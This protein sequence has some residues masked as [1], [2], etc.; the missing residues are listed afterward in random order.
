ML[1]DL[2]AIC[3]IHADLQ[4]TDRLW[5]QLR[6]VDR[7]LSRF[8]PQQTIPHWLILLEL[9]LS[10]L[11]PAVRV[12][13]AENLQLPGDSI[14]RLRELEQQRTALS[15]LPAAQR[16][17]QVVQILGSFDRSTLILLAATAP[18]PIRQQIWQYLTRWSQ[19]KSPLNGE[20]LKEL[21]YKPGKQFKQILRELKIATVDGM[22]N[23]RADAEAFL[24]E[25]F[26]VA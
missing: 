14:R 18:R 2:G 21:G 10:Q 7:A 6:L 25:R 20:A 12:A 15:A 23:T 8:D 1:D 9:I 22:V 16:P 4:L 17:S 24:A 26:P 11:E 13:V 5:R 19:I 3:C